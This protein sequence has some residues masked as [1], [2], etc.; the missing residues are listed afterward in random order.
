MEYVKWARD[1][2]WVIILFDH[3]NTEY[4][5]FIEIHNLNFS[6]SFRRVFLSNSCAI[7]LIHLSSGPYDRS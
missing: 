1:G 3:G 7:L 2:V 4:H 6:L 5:S